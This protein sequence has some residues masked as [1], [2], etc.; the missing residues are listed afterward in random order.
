MKVSV[1][2]PVHPPSIPYLVDAYE[3]LRSQELPD[4]WVWEWLVQEDGRTGKVAASLPNDPRILSGTGKPGGPGTARNMAMA[5]SDGDL[6][7][8]LDGDDQLTPGALAREI[9]ILASQADIGWTTCSVLDLMPDGSTIGWQHA[10][11]PDGTL[12]Q[13]EV[14]TYFRDNGYR[15]PVHPATLCIRR[16]LALALGGWMALPGGE[17]TGL[18]LAA[19]VVTDGSFIAEPGLLYRKHS[20]QI[21]AQSD[22]TAT[23]EWQLRMQ[24]I[25]ARAIAL[26]TPFRTASA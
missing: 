15:L 11:P 14:L 10:D 8:V 16:E 22:W 21:T 17:D 5:R 7:R 26:Q 2:T 24:L 20:D 1:I 6:L 23:E 25:E 12:Q 9:E 18:L 3:S 4:G 13:G 19:S